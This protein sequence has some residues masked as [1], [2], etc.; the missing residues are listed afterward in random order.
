MTNEAARSLTS[1][2]VLAWPIVPMLAKL[3][4][5]LPRDDSHWAFEF[6]WDGIRGVARIERGALSLLSRNRLDMTGR[7]PE[8][9][10]LAD[11]LGERSAVLDGEVVGFDA[12]GRPTFEALQQRM[13]LEGGKRVAA[14][15]GVGVAY[16]IFDLL[17]LDGRSLLGL[18][19]TGR[20]AALEDLG[21]EGSHWHTPP[22]AVGGGDLLLQASREQRMEGVVAKRLDSRYEPGKR[23]GAWLKIKNQQRQQFVI[24][25]WV[26]ARASAR[27]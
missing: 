17:Y 8:L 23:T 10:R 7:Y 20:R 4:P 19:Y 16:I 5:A 3:A 18:P 11:A 9:R 12:S 22:H 1:P 24:G 15:R 14:D 25:G 26:P 2:G 13:G 27:A 6:K 21:L